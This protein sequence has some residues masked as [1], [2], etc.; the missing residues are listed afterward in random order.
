MY[1]GSDIGFEFRDS[2]TCIYPYEARDAYAFASSGG[3]ET[4]R[5]S[6]DRFRRSGQGFWGGLSKAL[7]SSV[8]SPVD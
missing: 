6:R 1:G 8:S 2:Q 7:D 4:T 3:Y 5:G